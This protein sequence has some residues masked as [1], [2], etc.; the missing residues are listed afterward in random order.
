MGARQPHAQQAFLEVFIL[1]PYP[2]TKELTLAVWD[3]EGEKYAREVV[4]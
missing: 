3:E 4:E 2:W 1:N